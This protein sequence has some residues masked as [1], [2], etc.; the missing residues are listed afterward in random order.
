MYEVGE[1][2]KVKWKGFVKI[3]TIF[4]EGFRGYQESTGR[5]IM[6]RNSEV[7]GKGP[8]ARRGEGK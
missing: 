8:Q 2:V 1:T 5:L 4:D 3:I 7:S 6:V